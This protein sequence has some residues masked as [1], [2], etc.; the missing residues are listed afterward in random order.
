MGKFLLREL[1]HRDL[2][3]VV[4]VHM[5]SF[6]DRALSQFGAEAVKR[7][8]ALL[9][10]SHEV[11]YPFCVVNSEGTIFGFCYLGDYG[12]ALR[13]FLKQNKGYLFS[14]IMIHPGLLFKAVIREQI[15]LALDL[16]FES[17]KKEGKYEIAE[18]IKSLDVQNNKQI[19]ILSIA[20]DPK[21]Q[22]MGMGELLM[23]HA[24]V[25]A[26]DHHYDML[27]LTVHPENTSAVRFYEKMG[28]KKIVAGG[29][30]EGQMI[31][32]LSK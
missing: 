19:S 10:T 28:W 1:V 15:K 31:K 29:Q 23:D 32:D 20:V 14:Y 27:R 11:S 17:N 3:E 2:D 18:S 12:G 30:W 13:K 4:K 5:A 7:Y 9:M 8:Y 24:E 25:I 22:R 26:K 6:H 16:L 21:Y